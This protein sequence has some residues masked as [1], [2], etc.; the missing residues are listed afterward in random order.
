MQIIIIT[1]FNNGNRPHLGEEKG[2]Q[3]PLSKEWIQY[4][5]N[6]WKKF[7]LQSMLNQTYKDWIWVIKC[8][9]KSKNITKGLFYQHDR[10][11]NESHSEKNQKRTISEFD[12]VLLIQLASDDMYRKDAIEEFHKAALIQQREFYLC[13]TGYILDLSNLNLAKYDKNS[14]PFYARL[15]NGK[16]HGMLRIGMKHRRVKKENPYIM[17]GNMYMVGI[18]EQN[19]SSRMAIQ[20]GKV[21]KKKWSEILKGFG[22]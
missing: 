14:P 16:E 7:T 2:I 4:R 12:D 5:Y 10:R 11:I 15:V 19:T 1:G 17:P 3:R 21:P 6:I 22:V 18:H 9:S 8:H 13:N 20:T